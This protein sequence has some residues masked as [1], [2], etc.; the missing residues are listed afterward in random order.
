MAGYTENC[1]V[2]CC[3]NEECGISEWMYTMRT[4]KKNR[5]RVKSMDTLFKISFSGYISRSAEIGSVPC[6][7]QDSLNL[8]FISPLLCLC[9]QPSI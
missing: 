6:S 7:L 4:E 1:F 2:F 3:I 5:I 8:S 9:I